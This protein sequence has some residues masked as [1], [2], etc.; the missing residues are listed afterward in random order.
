MLSEKELQ[1]FNENVN[2]VVLPLSKDEVRDLVINNCGEKHLLGLKN[3][4]TMD[5]FNTVLDDYY[6]SLKSDVYLFKKNVSSKEVLTE[7]IIT[8]LQTRKEMF[9]FMFWEQ[10]VHSYDWE[11]DY[12]ED[13]EV[14]SAR[15]KRLN[16]VKRW[17][18]RHPEFH[19]LTGEQKQLSTYKFPSYVVGFSWRGWGALMAAYMNSKCKERLYDYTSFYM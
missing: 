10:Y 9:R 11:Y 18:D 17:L 4:F 7:S 2:K 19:G 13:Y 3:S 16:R 12:D 15:V 5:E 14:Y 8:T 1:E 6:Y